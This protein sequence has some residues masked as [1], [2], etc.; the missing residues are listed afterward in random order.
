VALPSSFLAHCRPVRPG[1][2][3][4]GRCSAPAGRLRRGRRCRA[5]GCAL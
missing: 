4:P 1:P 5:L 3:I 2:R